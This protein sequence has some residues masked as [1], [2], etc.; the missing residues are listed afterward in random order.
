MRK[1]LLL[2][3]LLIVPLL[4][5]CGSLG[6][7]E[8]IDSRVE[9]A[10]QDF[11][12]EEEIMA[13][14]VQELHDY[15][16]TNGYVLL[17]DLE[18]YYYSIE[19]IDG[20]VTDYGLEIYSLTDLVNLIDDMEDNVT[21]IE[22]VK[23]M[24]QAMQP[25][26]VEIPQVEVVTVYEPSD[27]NFIIEWIEESI[28][29]TQIVWVRSNEVIAIDIVYDDPLF[30]DTTADFRYIEYWKDGV[31]QGHYEFTGDYEFTFILE[32]EE[33]FSFE[34]YVSQIRTETTWE[35]VVAFYDTLKLINE[36]L[37]E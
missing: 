30:G 24:I 14:V 3:L 2:M 19:D 31:S 8:L 7:Q 26:I 23:A 16:V 4:S 21:D 12:T 25:L 22:E 17:K 13:I 15:D 6:D 11:L 37:E 36:T 5:S 18:Q 20:M 10:M 29:Y 33:V 35:M 1:I 34:D 32:D 27:F 28:P 9:Y